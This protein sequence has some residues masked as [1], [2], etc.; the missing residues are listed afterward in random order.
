MG[1]PSEVEAFLSFSLEC[2]QNRQS[3]E[4]QINWSLLERDHNLEDLGHNCEALDK[5]LSELIPNQTL[6]T[7]PDFSE[8]IQ[9][10]LTNPDFQKMCLDA[11]KK[12]R[13]MAQKRLG[14]NPEKT[15]SRE[16]RETE[17][18]I[19]SYREHQRI[20]TD[21]L[22]LQRQVQNALDR[23]YEYMTRAES[24][25]KE[26]EAARAKTEEAR[27]EVEEAKHKTEEAR[28]KTEEAR[29]EVEEAR[30]KT[31]QAENK[32]KTIKA[33]ALNAQ[34]AAE[35]IIPNMLT[36]LGIFIAIVVA[37]VAC[38]LSLIFNKH[39]N[40][41]FPTLNLCV[42]LLMG[43]ILLNVIFLL[44]YLISK[45]TNYALACHCYASNQVDCSMCP[46]AI[47]R[48][49]KMSNRIWY[50]YPYVVLLNGVFILG[51]FALGVW[52]FIYSYLGTQIDT[53]FGKSTTRVFYAAVIL[54]LLFFLGCYFVYC[55]MVRN[56][57][58]RKAAT[59]EGAKALQREDELRKEL[60]ALKT[61]VKVLEAL[62]PND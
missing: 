12:L 49:C 28:A 3:L 7:N 57:E 34:R 39:Q 4:K 13:D 16:A 23:S 45:L 61:R 25:Q 46:Q 29:I 48:H 55:V 22:K 8:G 20:Y 43:H 17:S 36:T 15:T 62:K 18:S 38:Y 60:D 41:D 5:S 53:F 42:C 40:P 19:E 51:Y 44:M 52:Y 6:P 24:L 56:P 47:R 14:S 32:T 30:R 59:E 26:T 33:Q 31:K 37:V 21:T 54:L 58:L 9:A 27:I 1:P 10:F 2:F 50:R 35:S 11:L